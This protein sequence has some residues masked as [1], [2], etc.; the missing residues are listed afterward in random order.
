[1][2]TSFQIILFI[3][4][5]FVILLLYRYYVDS[6]EKDITFT[7]GRKEDKVR[8]PPNDILFDISNKQ[9][10]PTIIKE[11]HK[12]DLGNNYKI[13]M[14]ENNDKIDTYGFANELGEDYKN[15]KK[16]SVELEETYN[17]S[18]A[19]PIIDDSNKCQRKQEKSDLPIV[20]VPYYL[21]ENNTSLRLS[22]KPLL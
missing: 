7:Q 15:S 14:Y 19:N 10:T 2:D 12:N 6:Y 20:N 11:L 22:E 18:V 21:L 3:I 16:F 1:M 17:K 9:N 8:C 4:L 5:L 13:N